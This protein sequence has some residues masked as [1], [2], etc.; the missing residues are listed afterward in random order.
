MNLIEIAFRSD[1]SSY[2]LYIH[3]LE[4][5][6]VYLVEL[7]YGRDSFQNDDE[8]RLELNKNSEK[9]T[10]IYFSRVTRAANSCA[11]FYSISDAVK[12][13]D[14]VGKLIEENFNKEAA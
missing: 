13:Y 1:A 4:H 5:L 7:K 10:V 12:A 14:E 2:D 6:E 11:L 8:I 3:K 9:S